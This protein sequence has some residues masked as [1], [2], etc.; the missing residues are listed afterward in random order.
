MKTSFEHNEK[1]SGVAECH[2]MRNDL[3]WHFTALQWTKEG[4]IEAFK[5][6]WQGYNDANW[7]SNVAPKVKP[8]RCVGSLGTTKFFS[9]DFNTGRVEEVEGGAK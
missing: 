9:I 4:K 6:D 8:Q 2:I 1:L 7:W 5:A 3:F